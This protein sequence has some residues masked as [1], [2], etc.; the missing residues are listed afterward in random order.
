MSAT[1]IAEKFEVIADAVYEAGQKS[2]YDRFWDE[3]QQ[4]GNRTNYSAAFSALWTA[5]IFK[6]KY[7]IR[8]IN[9]Y[10]MFLNNQGYGIHIL[11]FVQ[12]CKENNVV[13]DYSQCTNAYYGISC[14]RSQHYGV[15]DFSKCTTMNGLFYAQN[16]GDTRYSVRKIDEFISSE[17]TK[18]ANDTF[19][20]AIWLTDIKMSGVVATSIN[21]GVCP[22][23][24]Q[25]L[26]SV[27][28]VLLKTATGQTLTLKKSAVDAAFETSD[29]ANDG[30]SSTDWIDLITEYSNQYNGN[31]TIS[32]V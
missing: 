19:S 24:K 28:G 3:F 30:S 10:C 5:E 27:I 13:L 23:N 29:G 4:N 31:W 21:F 1:S 7:P 6:P 11:D 22:L 26:E 8:P 2:E 14:L 17:I 16:S 20:G 15:L 25:S 9:A 32:L 18:F 12:F